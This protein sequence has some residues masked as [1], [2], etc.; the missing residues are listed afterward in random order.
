M[1]YNERIS[2]PSEGLIE[3]YPHRMD[4][5][6]KSNR[7]NLISESSRHS[8]NGCLGCSIDAQLGVGSA[9][10]QVSS[11]IINIASGGRIR[12]DWIV[13]SQDLVSDLE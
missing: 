2:V 12:S 9:Y 11:S 5:W 8:Q 3:S 1:P 7:G 6:G 10:P 4:S 13:E